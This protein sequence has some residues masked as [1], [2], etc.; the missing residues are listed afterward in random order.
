MRKKPYTVIGIRRMK[1]FRCGRPARHQWQI[2]ADGS[3]YRPICGACG[4]ND[5]AWE[6]LAAYEDTNLTP[7]E[8]VDL[9]SKLSVQAMC[10]AGLT[11]GIPLD[12]LEFI[13]TAEREGRCMV[14]PCK[15]ND[16]VWFV[17]CTSMDC[18]E[19]ENLIHGTNCKWLN[20]P[21]CP[22]GEVRKVL[23]RYDMI[24]QYGKTVFLTRPEAEAALQPPEKTE[25]QSDG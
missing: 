8:I 4:Y 9:Q 6:K 5:D 11:P 22:K 15:I 18:D 7:S 24:P 19:C 14:L 1:C 17:D 25:A 3:Q 12:R 21:I 23:F 2:C 10:R 16:W 13:C 20:K